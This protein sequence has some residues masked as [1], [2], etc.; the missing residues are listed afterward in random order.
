MFKAD[1]TQSLARLSRH[2]TP[3]GAVNEFCRRY[4]RH[5]IAV[6]Q[7]GLLAARVVA[8]LAVMVAWRSASVAD[9]FPTPYNSEA[10]KAAQPMPA[11]EAAARFGLPDGFEVS[12]FASE[13]DIQNPIAMT[14]DSRGRMWVAENY[15]YAERAARFDLSLRDRVVILADTTGDGV[16]DRRT[17]FTDQV[18]MLTAVEVGHGGVWLMCPP[19]VLFI[20]DANGDDIPDGPAEVVL[21]GFEVARDNYHNFANGLR[22]GPDGWLYGRCGGSCPGRIGRPGTAD[23][24]R[25]ALEGGVWRYHPATKRV[26]VL[27][28]GTTNPWGHDWNAVGEM[29]FVNTVNG[30][31]WHMIPGAHYVRPFTLD[32]NPRTYQTIDMH[33]DHWHF[34]T[35][36]S[37]TASRDGAANS[38]GGGHAHIGTMIY[39]ADQWPAEYRGRLMTLNLHGRRVNQ[40]LLKRHGSGYIASHLDDILLSEDP[41]FRGME[42]SCGPEGSVYVLDWSDTGEC[43]EHTGVHRTSGRVFRVSYREGLQKIGSSVDTVPR[44][45]RSLDNNQLID[46][47]GHRNQWFVRQSRLILQERLTNAATGVDATDPVAKLRDMV[48]SGDNDLAVSA[49]MTLIAIDRLD[50]SFALAM[51]GHRHESVRVWAI[52][53]LTDRVPI[54]DCYG[55]VQ[56]VA[57][58]DPE[59]KDRLIATANHDQ[60]G[61]VRLALASV[62]QRLP[63]R[64]RSELAMALSNRV[65]DA[66]DHNLPLMVWYGLMPV[67]QSAAV[68]LAEVASASRW[69]LLRRLATRR[70]AE[71][72]AD[73]DQALQ[74]LVELTIQRNDPAVYRD[75]IAG[76]ADG[77]KGWRK[78]TAPS[79]WD[80]LVSLAKKSNPDD[81]ETAQRLGELGVL[82]GDG[83]SMD[84]VRQIVLDVSEE[85]GVR[86]SALLALIQQ[87]PADLSE[88]CGKVLQDARINSVAARGLALDDSPESAQKMV[89]AYRRFRSP[90]RPKVIEILT[91]RPSFASVLLSAIEAGKIPRD[92]VSAYDARAIHSL[93][94]EILSARVGEVW[95][96]IRQSPQ[97]RHQAMIALKQKLLAADL[98]SADLPAGRVVYQ[99]LCGKCHKLYG[100][101]Q[102]IGPDLTGSNRNNL[103]YLIENVIDPSAVVSKDYRVS[104]LKMDDGRVLNGVVVA[105]N[106]R[107]IRLQ[108]Q[109]ELLVID[110]DEVEEIRLTAQSPMPEGQLENL[111]EK[112]IRDLFAYLMHPVQVQLPAGAGDP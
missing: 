8:V 35:G 22:F 97:E 39:Q 62:L 58:V 45:L 31:L 61:L 26:E 104:L 1:H 12:V 19:Q 25:F 89:E 71:Q 68:E 53:G 109:T 76:V 100:E 112:Q 111:S 42:L 46:L 11:D 50:Q 14:W 75:V 72:L 83:R 108:T 4:R 54:D 103:D 34:D 28:A 33:A 24:Q 3:F 82:F 99:N 98:G 21:D 16:A 13:P 47:H 110:Q 64:D 20:P 2:E 102:T 73:D 88:V 77:L 15:T 90:E 56:T 49:M 92:E 67:S 105:R 51:L 60:S 43:H 106:D 66:D 101:G 48:Q 5:C 63:I 107:V 32:P 84:E 81:Q 57:M 86:R 23:D 29:F 93:G 87:R 30:H 40:E 65:E 70:I 78:A 55:P 85:I 94:D 41:F 10:D 96:E 18:Q 17:V 44:D 69:P 59:I 91:S 7:C 79:G 80:R 6:Q 37:W 38:L 9:D 74:W 27:C 36:K 52:R 95:G